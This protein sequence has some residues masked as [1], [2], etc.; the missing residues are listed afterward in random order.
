MSKKEEPKD[1]TKG[2]QNSSAPPIKFSLGKK[3]ANGEDE[4]A[5]LKTKEQVEIDLVYSEKQLGEKGIKMAKAFR[6][7]QELETEK[8]RVMK[9]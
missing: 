8:S 5:P 4:I 6:E 7:F 1:S 3:N 9:E 2:H